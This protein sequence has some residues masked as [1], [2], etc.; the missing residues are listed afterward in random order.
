M[1]TIEIAG[2]KV[3]LNIVHHD[4]GEEPESACTNTLIG[5][6]VGEVTYQY[7]NLDPQEAIRKM[8]VAI[9]SAARFNPAG[10]VPKMLTVVISKFHQE[11]TIDWKAAVS[12]LA[13]LESLGH[14]S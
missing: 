3:L 12:T 13:M 6:K 10:S 1:P 8:V 5:A 4:S 14:Q 7:L 9:S 2:K 11:T